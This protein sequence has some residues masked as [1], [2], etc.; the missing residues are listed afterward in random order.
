MSITG[1]YMGDMN[2]GLYPVF[3]CCICAAAWRDVSWGFSGL[4]GVENYPCAGVTMVC[5]ALYA[6]GGGCIPPC[7]S[8]VKVCSSTRA[9]ALLHIADL[10]T[11]QIRGHNGLVYAS[12]V[13]RVFAV[14]A[15]C[16]SA[17]AL[18]HFH[19]GSGSKSGLWIAL[20][21]VHSLQSTET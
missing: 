11:K 14:L 1:L 9:K 6:C 2:F 10:S 7:T 18:L 13:A 17:A 3:I 20:G 12:A 16:C 5:P 4:D 21:P 19:L 15:G 8:V